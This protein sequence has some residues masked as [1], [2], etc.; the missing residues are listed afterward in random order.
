VPHSPRTNEKAVWSLACSWDANT[1]S[2]AGLFESLSDGDIGEVQRYFSGKS[3]QRQHPLFLPTMLLDLLIVFYVGHRRRLEHSLFVVESQLGITRGKRKTDA[4]DWD[5]ELHRETTKHCNTVYTSLV[6]LERQLDFAS[7][8]A[9]FVLQCI[10]YCHEEDV[11]P[12]QQRT[13]LMR[14][15]K[16]MEEGVVNNRNFAKCQLHQVLCLQK[17]AQ[18]LVSVVRRPR[19]YG[20]EAKLLILKD[21]FTR[22]LPRRT[23]EP[24]S[25]LQKRQKKIAHL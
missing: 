12:Q 8:L 10:T 17:R 2:T 19:Q 20:N 25:G 16:E 6:Y 1:R 23:A 7:R 21:R 15:S 4:W 9:D 11:F 24:T 5:Y 3:E 18:A 13:Y 14:V 22:S